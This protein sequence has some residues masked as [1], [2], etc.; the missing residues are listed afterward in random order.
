VHW[1]AEKSMAS[2]IPFW[3]SVSTIGSPA[4]T[5]SILQL[6]SFPAPQKMKKIEL[7]ASVLV[8]AIGNNFKIVIFDVKH[9]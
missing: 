1:K 7:L 2:S 6:E 3:L 4:A 5:G 8:A 9:S